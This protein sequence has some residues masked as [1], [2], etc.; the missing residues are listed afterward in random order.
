MEIRAKDRTSKELY[1]LLTGVIVPRPIAFVSTKS[2]EGVNN[3]AP[4]SFFNAIT[5][6]PPTIM[7]SIGERRGE[8]KDTLANIEKHPQFVV[9]IVTEDLAQPMHNSAAEFLP[10]VSE[11]DEVGLTPVPAQLIDCMAVKESP[12]H[13]ECELDQVIQVG[14]SYMVLGRVVHLH[15]EDEVMIGEDKIDVAKLKPLARLAGNSYGRV[16]DA[17]SLERQFDPNKVIR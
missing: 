4:F 1:K 16:R 2:A 3:L 13:L 14:K 11:F 7:I 12:V 8:K 9:N 15:I 6:D 5:S 17:F 10:E